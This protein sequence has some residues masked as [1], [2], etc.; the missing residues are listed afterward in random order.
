[1]NSKSNFIKKAVCAL[2]CMV[3]AVAFNSASGA[4]LAA[5]AGLLL[6]GGRCPPR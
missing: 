6:H 4:V 5:V 3:C 2:F 1:M